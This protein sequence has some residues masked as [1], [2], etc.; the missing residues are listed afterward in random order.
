MSKWGIDVASEK[1]MKKV[2]SELIGDNLEAELAPMSFSH[3]DR[4]DVIKDAPIVYSA[5]S[6]KQP[7]LCTVRIY[8]PLRRLQLFPA[9][10][11]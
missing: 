6:I 2:A 5:A 10:T 7:I 8:L 1:R 11:W 4:G 3:K 9:Q